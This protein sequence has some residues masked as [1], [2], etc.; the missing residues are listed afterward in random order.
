M[1]IEAGA[2][3]HGVADDDMLHAVRNHRRAFETDDPAVTMYIGS[4]T[5]AEPLEVGVVDDDQGT[6]VIHAMPA[7]PDFL[8]GWW[9]P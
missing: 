4:T 9:R 3:K 5:T 8:T 1:D 6:A 2:R 7:R